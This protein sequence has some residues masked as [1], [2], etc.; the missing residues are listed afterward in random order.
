MCPASVVCSLESLKT[1]VPSSR[2][3][4]ENSDPCYTD[5]PWE[6]DAKW[7]KPDTREQILYASHSYDV[8]RVVK[9][10]ARKQNG[11]YQGKRNGELSDE[12]RIPISQNGKSSEDWLHNDVKALNPTEP[13]I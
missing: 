12:Y 11:N 4:E 13:S 6:H 1:A 10:R 2:T 7:R 5:D 8:S 9:F 3:K